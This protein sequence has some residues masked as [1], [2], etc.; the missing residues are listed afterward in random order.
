MKLFDSSRR[1]FVKKSLV[2]GAALPF[3]PVLAAGVESGEAVAASSDTPV[4]LHW[5]EDTTS[6]KAV[7][8]TWGVPWPKSKH[9]KGT[10]F[11]L[12]NQ[13]GNS[14]A[15]Q[16]WPLAYWP[17]GSLKWTAH[18][19]YL[20]P[21][22]AQGLVLSPVKAANPTKG[23]TVI[24]AAN[25]ITV[26]T[27]AIRCQI[28]KQGS[29][30][31]T[32]I[33][34]DGRA[35]AA[36]GRL[37]LLTQDRVDAEDE[38]VTRTQ[39]FTGEISQVT[40]EQSGPVR[41]VIKLEGKHQQAK[42]SRAWLPFVV[43][44]YFYAGSEAVRVLHTITYDGDE[45]H[46][47][48][49]GIGIRFAV[50]L[51]APLHDRHVRFVGEDQG[52]FV[53]AVRGLTGLR[54]DPGATITKAQVAGQATDEKSF[55]AEVAGH[56]DLIPAFGDYILLQPSADSF[57]IRKRTRKGFTWLNSA[58][59]KRSAG[60]AY[61][62]T[63][64]GGLAFGIKNFWQS[65]P[66]QLDIRN[67]VTDEADVT[68]WLWAPEAPPMDLRFYHDGLGQD[69]FA[70]QREGLDIT[71]EDYEP[72]FGT[73]KGVARTSELML[74]ALPATPSAPE[75]SS[76]ATALQ[77]PPVL[78]CTPVYLQDRAVFGNNW[79]VLN[80]VLPARAKIEKQLA[81]YFDFYKNQVDQRSWYGFW[82]YGDVMHSY[83]ASRHV[84][85]YD[86]GGFAW[87]NSELSTD[88]WLWYYFLSTGRADV[89]RMA[90][91]M[92]RHTGEV[93]VHHLGPFAPLGSRHN[94]L[95]WGDSAK[96]LRI[97]TAA[98][99]RFYYYLTGDERVGDLLRE[100]VP[101]AK[102]LLTI[103]PG[104]KLPQD[105]P[106]KS[107]VTKTEAYC[108]FGTDWGAIAAAWLMEWE[109]TGD[110]QI[111][112]KL[113]NSMQTIAAQPHGFFTGSALLDVETGKFRLSTDTKPY[114]QHLNAVFGLPEVCAE[115][116]TLVNMPEFER[117]WLAYCE[118]YNAP[119]AEQAARLGQSLGKL[120]LRQG[121]SRLTAFAANRKKDKR[122]AQRAWD[123]FY[124][125][126]G[127][128]TTH[129]QA[130]LLKGPEVL[131]PI[132]EVPDISTNSVA[133]WG[134]AAIQCLALVGNE[135]PNG[136]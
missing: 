121:H 24:E 99:R 101:A 7:G 62:G 10:A 41:A 103:Q 68:L 70:K 16:S 52:V 86:I 21:V 48:I 94:V 104:R 123:E 45:N 8:V 124:H 116:I 28:N 43:R 47:F 122:L 136:L 133:Q 83:D 3:V 65:H 19:A 88:M 119:E 130:H 30:L 134:L 75:L 113:L 97:S 115:L 126:S 54:R 109:R 60:L 129:P 31:I 118:L 108:S 72:G 58:T 11:S 44:L 64:T 6:T 110:A 37:V 105:D 89:F 90:E 27:G 46:D 111:K 127:G 102:A 35:V 36:A 82:N 12:R 29:T 74:W 2:M 107:G 50:P 96:Q 117:A 40:V 131:T 22:Q 69:T 23:L 128:L 79:S 95:H 63:P 59:G 135:I 73:P 78:A 55:P 76:L 25:A 71:Y 91:A 61:L 98:N 42:A 53:E 14:F 32:A 26:D 85:K 20:A 84:W 33:T 15:V 92:T 17:D 18:A 106:R 5:L 51:H 120:N 114:A 1:A 87:D 34:R 132:D 56:L 125:A 66:A 81:W 80:P 93:D 57:A 39:E 100:Q 112:Q 38:G 4:P 9:K 77:T 13:Q 49:K 67:A